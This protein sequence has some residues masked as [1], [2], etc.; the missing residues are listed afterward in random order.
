VFFLA[1]SSSSFFSD[2]LSF[3]TF[4]MNT[5]ESIFAKHEG[6]LFYPYYGRLIVHMGWLRYGLNG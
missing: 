4:F 6:A 5:E 2:V 1:S 3:L